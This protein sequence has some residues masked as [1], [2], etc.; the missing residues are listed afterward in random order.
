MSFGS[1]F[2]FKQPTS[3]IAA[4]PAAFHPA[5]DPD[6]SVRLAA[7]DRDFHDEKFATP[8]PAAA[9][10]TVESAATDPVAETATNQ[11]SANE[12]AADEIDINDP[13]AVLM[14]TIEAATPTASEPTQVP[15]A[16]AIAAKNVAA[17]N[18]AAG[19]VAAEN[20][21]NDNV[22]VV[23]EVA[24]AEAATTQEVI[25]EG[26]T[27]ESETE[28][29]LAA[30]ES[31]A[32]EA[33]DS[34]AESASAEPLE[35]AEASSSA[36]ETG[37]AADEIDLAPVVAIQ[38]TVSETIPD[39]EVNGIFRAA[40]AATEIILHPPATEAVAE[41]IHAL[42]TEIETADTSAAE[43]ETNAA[44]ESPA[45][46][47]SEF[48][49]HTQVDAQVDAD[50]EAEAPA[51]LEVA[52]ILDA[53][54]ALAAD[55]DAYVPP[56]PF[57]IHVPESLTLEASPNVE[58]PAPGQS[59]EELANDLLAAQEFEVAQALAAAPQLNNLDQNPARS[60]AHAAED[61]A[62]NATP[63]AADLVETFDLDALC[64]P[65]ENEH[66]AAR[67]SNL[68]MDQVIDHAIAQEEAVAEMSAAAEEFVAEQIA[69][70]EKTG[71]PCPP[72]DAPSEQNED[73]PAAIAGSPL[74][75]AA[76]ALNAE[77]ASDRRRKRRALISSPIR[78]RGIDVTTAGPDEIA[79]TV[80]VSR[81]GIL[82]Y[83]VLE[84]YQR[85]M[86]VAVV[87]PYHKSATGAQ[88]EQFGRVVRLHDMPDGRHAVAIALG[89]G[90]G[91]HLVDASGRK[92]EDNKIHL[93]NSP[94]PQVKRPLVLI[95]DSDDM[96]RD[97]TKI[98]LQNEG[99]EVIAVNNAG[100]AREV[101]NMFMP[102][103]IVAEIEGAADSDVLPG[104]D[105]CAHVKSSPSL[106]H[107]PV[108]MTSRS[109]YPSDYSNAHSLGAVVCMAKPY[110][111]ERLGHVV[112]LLAPL[113]E[114]L[115]PA[116]T[117]RPPDPTRGF[118]R[119]SNVAMRNGNGN[120]KARNG[121]GKKPATN[122]A[123]ALLKKSFKFP[124]FR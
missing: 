93:T 23:A 2:R 85:G 5:L 99:Y 73:T 71:H 117:Q 119:D 25:A 121:N 45:H 118:T 115:Q 36:T 37:S 100:D 91:E 3:A 112:R 1:I 96:L 52:P 4:E 92:L 9:E 38:L 53:S 78:V 18:V 19:N 61:S 95:V 11:A 24:T 75:S 122:G 30:V 104:L 81:Y 77:P 17:E 16:T 116:C 42:E 103:M 88:A 32:T 80:D 27:P 120:G 58:A 68:E 79:T 62:Q 43:S 44:Q 107:I 113:P 101:L 31:A 26:S 86:D 105:L 47:S 22:E 83:T 15:A 54:G 70:E 65:T 21:P 40:A 111:Q 49:A 109:A 97:T 46:S 34:V 59:P 48:S 14:Q 110:K 35:T 63:A 50:V 7:M 12:T 114:H 10:S 94:A 124:N 8:E 67:D 29:A 57:E 60:D 69:C 13:L 87:F 76:A 28:P 33:Q 102:A 98:F 123:A 56:P 20:I 108:V 74:E 66:L 41:D 64:A 39:V 90:I 82:F 106:K 6:A 51:P 72:P 84:T 55:A 89:V